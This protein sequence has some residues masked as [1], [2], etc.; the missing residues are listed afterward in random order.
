M[1]HFE[2][3]FKNHQDTEIYYQR[4]LPDD[5]TKAVI[6]LFHGLAEHGGRYKNLVEYLVPRGFAIFCL[7]LPGHGQSEGTRVYIDQ[8]LDYIATQHQFS[9][10]IKKEYPGKPVFA[11][12]H[13]MGG[14]IAA[15]YA[16]DYQEELTGILLS[17][18]L[19][20]VPDYVSGFTVFLGNLFS[21]LLPK[22][23]LVAID[24]EGISTDPVEVEAYDNDP[25]VYR[26]KTTARLA[27]EL[28]G[29]MDKL[30]QEASGITLPALVMTG[31]EDPLVNPDDA[32]FLHG[33]IGSRDKTLKVFDGFYHEIHNETDRDMVFTVV[34][35]WLNAHLPRQE[36]P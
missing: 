26:G 6:H 18:A 15:T 14:L 34:A 36:S 29:A 22:F 8:F 31:G 17:A 28:L 2:G 13:S 25:L 24:S 9:N 19:A 4:W 27:S 5:G 16:L 30:S 10:L 11:Y 7:D 23:P 3:T 20:R 21:T 32:P 1:R 12:G 33:M 35:D